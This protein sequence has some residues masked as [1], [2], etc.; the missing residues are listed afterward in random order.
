MEQ[1]FWLQHPPGEE[2]QCF[3]LAKQ[4]NLSWN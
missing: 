4:E 3:V 2:I 1:K